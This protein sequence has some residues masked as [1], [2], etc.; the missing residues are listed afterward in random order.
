[1]SA[2][3]PEPWRGPTSLDWWTE[4]HIAWPIEVANREGHGS[5]ADVIVAFP[6]PRQD[7]A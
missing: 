4:S 7:S 6:K 1:M 2:A 5:A 3:P